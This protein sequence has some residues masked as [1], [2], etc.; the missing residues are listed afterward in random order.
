MGWQVWYALR[1]SLQK[2]PLI[3]PANIPGMLVHL[4]REAFK[5]AMDLDRL[6]MVTKNGKRATLYQHFL[7][8]TLI[9]KNTSGCL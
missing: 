8:A 2:N 5:K 7:E 1:D 6:V 9:E 3:V 4:Y